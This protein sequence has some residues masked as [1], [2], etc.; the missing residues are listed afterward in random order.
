MIAALII[1]PFFIKTG[2][3]NE[4]TINHGIINALIGAAT[5]FV[6]LLIL[7]LVTSGKGIGA[8]DMRMAALIGLTTGFPEVLV[9]IIGGFILGGLTGVFLLLRRLKKRKEE[10]PFGPFLSLATI[11]TL[12]WGAAIVDWYKGLFLL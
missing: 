6:F 7:F 1:A 2:S 5:G 3:G 4:G 9:A 10:V 11:I 8:G 12:L